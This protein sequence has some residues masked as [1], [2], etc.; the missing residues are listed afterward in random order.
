MKHSLATSIAAVLVLS[1]G[2]LVSTAAF[3]DGWCV[4]QDE[5]SQLV[6]DFAAAEPG[7]RILDACASPGGKTIAMAARQAARGLLVAADL[8][9]RR[10]R[11]LQDTLRRCGAEAVRV[12]QAD[13]TSPLPFG[14]VFDRVLLDAPCSGLG[15]LRRD[16]DIKWRRTESGLA[17]LARV[18]GLMLDHVAAVTGPGGRV[19]YSTCSS[20]PEENG[21]V[22]EAFL[23]RTPGWSQDGSPLHTLPFRDGLEAFYAAML[24]RTKDLR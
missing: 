2:M 19:I 5:A 7:E 4:V 16:P 21:A 8:R 11:L 3:A 20:E 24:V 1:G 14:A 15:T 17:E 23:A 13:V 12:V 22:V 18:Q 10:V 6:G 9:Q